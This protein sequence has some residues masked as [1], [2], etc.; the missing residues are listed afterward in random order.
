MLACLLLRGLP[1]LPARFPRRGRGQGARV[2][3]LHGVHEGVRLRLDVRRGRRGFCPLC[4]E[5]GPD[6]RGAHGA[7]REV[8]ARRVVQQLRLVCAGERFAVLCRVLKSSLSVHQAA[9][10]FHVCRRVH[11]GEHVVGEGVV[12]IPHLL[13]VVCRMGDEVLRRLCLSRGRARKS[14]LD[15]P[16]RLHAHLPIVVLVDDLVFRGAVADVAALAIVHDD[17]VIVP[18]DDEVACLQLPLVKRDRA[19]TCVRHEFRDVDDAVF[20]LLREERG[21]AR[22]DFRDSLHASVSP[23]LHRLP[24]EARDGMF[25]R[26]C[27]ARL[28]EGVLC[29]LCIRFALCFLRILYGL[30]FLHLR[31]LHALLL[32]FSV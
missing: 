12:E 32:D 6:G 16:R 9:E 29:V 25:H 10:R 2:L 21:A 5:R 28:R 17:V 11:G 31:V 1:R 23:V 14:R 30:R 13:R 3:R 26:A 22:A 8:D 27:A 15:D 24:E 19:L 20:E 4:A 18:V 7:T